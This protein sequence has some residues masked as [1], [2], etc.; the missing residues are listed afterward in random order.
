MK[1]FKEIRKTL[2]EKVYRPPGRTSTLG[3]IML[4]GFKKQIER[5]KMSKI[6]EKKLTKMW[7]DWCM[8]KG[9]SAA[10][11]Y[12]LDMQKKAKLPEGTF[13][14][15]GMKGHKSAKWV[16][17]EDLSMDSQDYYRMEGDFVIMIQGTEDQGELKAM[18]KALKGSYRSRPLKG[19][20]SMKGGKVKFSPGA[21][22]EIRDVFDLIIDEK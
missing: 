14:L 15:F 8:K 20:D 19:L 2:N 12:I 6:D 4:Q 3:G 5:S 7:G 22:L 11:D 18:M 10:L 13:L 16:K 1:T 9:Y 17:E 21:V